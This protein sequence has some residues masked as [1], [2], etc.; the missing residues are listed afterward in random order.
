MFYKY[1]EKGETFGGE[2]HFFDMKFSADNLK[3]LN[4]VLMYV[5]RSEELKEYTYRR[6][7]AC[8]KSASSL[9][10]IK[11]AGRGRKSA[12]MFSLHTAESFL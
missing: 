2:F 10:E 1:D 12:S 4:T 11:Q 3:L 7:T 5:N 6:K 8:K 9:Y